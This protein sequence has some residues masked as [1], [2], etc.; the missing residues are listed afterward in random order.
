MK[1]SP[2]QGPSGGGRMERQDSRAKVTRQGSRARMTPSRESS[3]RHESSCDHHQDGGHHHHN[4]GGHH[5]HGQSDVEMQIRMLASTGKLGRDQKSKT[6]RDTYQSNTKRG[7]QNSLRSVNYH[8]S[9]SSDIPLQRI[10]H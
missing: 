8:V 9:L 10:L 2:R 1:L 6:V 7:W 3:Q 5:G 4:E